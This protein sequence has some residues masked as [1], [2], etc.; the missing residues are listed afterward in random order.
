M[1]SILTAALLDA[2]ASRTIREDTHGGT[3][4][5]WAEHGSRHG[6]SCR[7]GDYP[8]VIQAL[9]PDPAGQRQNQPDKEVS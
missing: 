4:L 9:R 6:W 5:D 3:A 8:G 1:K 7:T 2:G